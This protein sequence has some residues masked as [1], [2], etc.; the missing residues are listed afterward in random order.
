MLP[1][2][3]DCCK[4]PPLLPPPHPPPA[5]Q[6]WE[7][8]S[9]TDREDKTHFLDNQ[10]RGGERPAF[11]LNPFLCIVAHTRRPHRSAWPRGYM[12]LS[13]LSQSHAPPKKQ[14]L[15]HAQK[16]MAKSYIG[17]SITPLSSI[18]TT[19]HQTKPNQ[20]TQT[21]TPNPQFNP[22]KRMAKSYMG[23]SITT[24]RMLDTLAGDA[25]TAA[26][27][28]RQPLLVCAAGGTTG[29]GGVGWGGV[30]WGGVWWGGVGVGLGGRPRALAGGVH[31]AAPAGARCCVCEA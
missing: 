10:A 21:P 4:K 22:Q 11:R 9:A 14:T 6:A 28:M 19:P 31:A 24:L 27:F 13:A 7:A 29:W 1:A 26:P 20:P 15:H 18:P 25:A 23:L 12:G 3:W 5:P 8:L 30:G 17:L 16:R 2:A